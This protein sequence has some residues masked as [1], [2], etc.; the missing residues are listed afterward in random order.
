[1]K[2]YIAQFFGVLGLIV[3]I[4]SL[5]QKNKD[6]MLIFVVLNG[7]FFGIE[8]LLLNAF[9]AMWS[10]FFGILRTYISKEKEKKEK[11]DKWYIVAFFI[12]GYIFIGF[13]SFDGK[14]ISIL[15]IIA[16][17]IYVV[18]LWQKSPKR[19]RIGTLSM[20]IL[21]LIYDIVVKA[22]PSAI[23]DLLVMT[24]TI[25]AIITQDILKN[26]KGMKLNERN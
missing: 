23:T 3:M 14:L 5:F 21:W 4:I 16:E 9:V 26:K 13:V 6:K 24:F 17:V 2:Y 11:L 19:I 7:L 25:V 8:Y 1:M 12:V 18:S 15:P 20:V 22:Y 10:N